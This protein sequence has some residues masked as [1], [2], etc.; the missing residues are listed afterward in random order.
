V[1]ENGAGGRARSAKDGRRSNDR[2]VA[3]EDRFERSALP[4]SRLGMRR[5]GRR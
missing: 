2:T 3:A 4:P 5:G 1:N